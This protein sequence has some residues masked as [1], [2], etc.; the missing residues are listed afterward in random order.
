MR[1]PTMEAQA[2]GPAT[3]EALKRMLGLIANQ[4]DMAV[5]LL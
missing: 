5:A 4:Y 2:I 1:S 3:G